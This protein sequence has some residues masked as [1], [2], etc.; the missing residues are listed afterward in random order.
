M[1]T[2]SADALEER[3]RLRAAGTRWRK[4]SDRGTKMIALFLV[5]VH[6]LFIVSA[7]GCTSTVTRS[8]TESV[9]VETIEYRD[10]YQTV[11]KTVEVPFVEEVKTPNYRVTRKP[12]IQMGNSPKVIGLLPF[13]VANGGSEIG[14]KII[15]LIEKTITEHQDF[16]NRF[17][18]IGYHR[19]LEALGKT[20]VR[21]IRQED[22][23]VLIDRLNIELLLTGHVKSMQGDQLVIKLD[24][25]DVKTDR[26]V[27]GEVLSGKPAMVMKRVDQI[28]YGSQSLVGYTVAKVN[29]TRIERQQ[30]KELVKKPYKTTKYEEK[31]VEYQ[32]K[33]FDFLKT[34]L[35]IGLTILIANSSK[36]NG[37]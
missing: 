16:R 15:E 31:T 37:N 28:F 14:E 34:A 18:V 32:V 6:F 5:P 36:K 7:T 20:D 23:Q 10:E 22:T 2:S 3:N 17:K 8:R 33:V 24:V 30:V 12:S 4:V 21:M 25:F 26:S 11:E 13:T 9:P 27:F 1:K 35:A 19:I 29:K